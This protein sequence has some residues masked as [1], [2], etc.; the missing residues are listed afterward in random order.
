MPQPECWS[1]PMLSL[2]PGRRS[3]PVR[4]TGLWPEW[5]INCAYFSLWYQLVCRCIDH[6]SSPY[7]NCNVP[8]CVCG[9]LKHL[10]RWVGVRIFTH[11]R[12]LLILHIHTT[13]HC[14]LSLRIRVNGHNVLP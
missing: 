5:L 2:S 1:A 6:F 13:P 8:V 12:T 11:W 3:A 14:L 4:T 7:F 10:S 9:L